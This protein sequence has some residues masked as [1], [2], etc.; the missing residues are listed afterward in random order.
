MSDLPYIGEQLIDF[1]VEGEIDYYYK[2]S[3]MVRFI[4][5]RANVDDHAVKQYFEEHDYWEESPPEEHSIAILTQERCFP[6]YPSEDDIVFYN[7]D[8]P[9]VYFYYMPSRN[10]LTGYSYIN[11]RD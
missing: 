3:H 8:Y 11:L 5:F 1:P 9:H 6:I 10:E 7:L 4:Y 2:T